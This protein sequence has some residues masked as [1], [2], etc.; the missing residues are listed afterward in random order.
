[1]R[2]WEILTRIVEYL[3]GCESLV[4]IPKYEN[5]NQLRQEPAGPDFRIS[6]EAVGAVDEPGD[7]GVRLEGDRYERT[8]GLG[9]AYFDLAGRTRECSSVLPR[10]RM[11]TLD[12]AAITM[13][14]FCQQSESTTYTFISKTT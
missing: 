4:K 8:S 9:E 5:T 1:M 14:E 7:G 11:Y 13:I 3:A 2:I 10:L 12:L 6:H